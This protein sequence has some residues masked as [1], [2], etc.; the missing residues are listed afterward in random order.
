MTILRPIW[1]LV[2]A[3]LVIVGVLT[4]LVYLNVG[5]AAYLHGPATQAAWQEPAEA[6]N[7]ATTSIKADQRIDPSRPEYTQEQRQFLSELQAADDER[8]EREAR[9][10]DQ[11][12]RGFLGEEE[13]SAVAAGNSRLHSER[14]QPIWPPSR[15]CEATKGLAPQGAG[16]EL[17]CMV[18]L[19]EN[20]PWRILR[21]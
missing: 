10:N 9:L 11:E 18:G 14:T 20:H 5:I 4:A 7:A 1:M 19:M 2:R 3:A 17:L 15:H 6:L 13:Q 8:F 12:R 21:A 16:A